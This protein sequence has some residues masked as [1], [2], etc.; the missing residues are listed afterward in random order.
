M[1]RPL[2]DRLLLALAAGDSLGS[3]SEFVRQKEIPQLYEKLRP[4]G[5]PFRQV[6]GGHFRW[7][8]GAPTDDTDMA[9]CL[10]RSALKYGEFDGE[11]VAQ[12]FVAWLDRAPK[13]A[14]MTT[15]RT[16][17]AVREG[18]P[19][20]RGALANFAMDPGNAANG[21]LMRNGV[22]AGIGD[23]LPDA[24]RI[25]ILH[26]LIT[27]YAPLP[28]LCCAAQTW[29]ILELL[30]TFSKTPTRWLSTRLRPPASMASANSPSRIPS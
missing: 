1:N 6:G 25:S 2:M 16:L 7:P 29:L 14:G 17:S 28:V 20:H 24:W 9:L 19:W 8:A 10:V 27:H 3:T 26:S 15:I 23:D 30:G 5:W 12:R 4:G 21:S 22:V 18:V 11:D 13:D